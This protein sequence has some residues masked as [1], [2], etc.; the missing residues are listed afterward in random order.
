[1]NNESNGSTHHRRRGHCFT[2]ARAG[3]RP[4]PPLNSVNCNSLYTLRPLESLS[5]NVV[6][7]HNLL[8]LLSVYV[9]IS[10]F[11]YSLKEIPAIVHSQFISAVNNLLA[12]VL[13]SILIL[14]EKWVISLSCIVCLCFLCY[15]SQLLI[16][17]MK[18]VN[19]IWFLKQ[20]MIPL[21]GPVIVGVKMNVC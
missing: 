6:W 21:L 4:S 19:I 10:C 20:R 14:S 18:Y 12:F 1:M 11:L 13:S 5:S 3:L 2:D 17:C 7:A 8:D 9:I 15:T 16:P